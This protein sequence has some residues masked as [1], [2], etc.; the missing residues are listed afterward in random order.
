MLFIYYSN[1][2]EHTISPFGNM[3]PVGKILRAITRGCLSF[4]LLPRHTRPSTYP[5]TAS[6][7]GETHG[8]RFARR[9]H[10]LVVYRVD[11]PDNFTSS[12]EPQNTTHAL[13]RLLGGSWP[14]KKSNRH[15]RELLRQDP[16]EFKTS[17]RAPAATLSG[18]DVSPRK[19]RRVRRKPPTNPLA[20]ARKGNN[21]RLTTKRG[22]QKCA[23]GL[24]QT[25]SVLSFPPP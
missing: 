25:D 5:G 21:A 24:S 14:L 20:T 19:G 18:P 9:F 22:T 8:K 2:Q 23:A 1:T 10:L 6:G 3:Y 4:L 11:R 17:Q 12:H 7:L 15:C 13:F 16:R